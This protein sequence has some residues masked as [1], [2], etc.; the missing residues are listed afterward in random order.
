MSI[1]AIDLGGTKLAT[2]VFLEKGEMVSEEVI[3]LEKRKGP[4]VGLL[5]SSQVSK[6]LDIQQAEGNEINSIGISVPGIS[7]VKEARVWAPNI[8]GWEDYP[9]L[10][11]IMEVSGTIP[12]T[13]DSDRACYILGEVW[14]GN[15]QGCNDAIF[16]AVGTGIG[17]GIYANGAVLRGA[18]NISGAIGWMAL[19]KPYHKDYISSGCFEFHA[20][21]EGI[22]NTTRQLLLEKKDYK[23]ELSMHQRASITAQHVFNAYENHDPLAEKVIEICIEY[24]GMAVANLVSLFNPEKIIIGGG[25]FG[26]GKK[27]IEGIRLEAGKWAQP[28]SIQQVS[29]EL[30]ALE[31][32][33]GVYGA[34]Y[35]A[36]HRVHNI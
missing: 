17:A 14:Q 9:L 33:A 4:E 34:G 3:Y 5:I 10:E 16:L 26:P 19:D 23:G 21:G 2:A 20:S 15:A 6:I 12:V 30:S 27:F 18:H 7:R 24:W 31:G 11:E 1:L 8:P 25:V 29:I 22:A 36:L 32:N 13:I 35:L 28:I